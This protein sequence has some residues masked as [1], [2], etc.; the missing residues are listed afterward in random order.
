ME[1]PF[2]TTPA[3][4]RA[5][6]LRWLSIAEKLLSARDLMGSKSFATRAREADPTLSPAGEI[7]AVA[8]TLLSGDRRIGN[9][10]PDFY[11]VLRLT[12]PQGGDA[13]LVASQYRSLVVL[14]N[15]QNNRFPY[16]EQAFRLVIDAWSVLSNPSRK[17]LYDKELG[18]YLHHQQHQP[19]PFSL[20]IPASAPASQ[21]SFI[22]A[23]PQVHGGESSNVGTTHHAQAQQVHA[24]PRVGP[25]MGGPTRESQNFMGFHSGSNVVFGSKPVHEPVNNQGQDN[26]STFAGYN[27]ASSASGVTQEQNNNNKGKQSHQNYSNAGDSNNNN[28][29]DVN[30]NVEETVEEI[31]EDEEEEEKRE[32]LPLKNDPLTFWTACPYC[33][34]MYEYPRVYID[35]T[36]RCPNCKRAFQSVVIP[37]PPPT[38]DGQDAYYCCWGFIP[39]GFSMDIYEKNKGPAPT[40]GTNSGR[41]NS[42]PRV[43][44]DDDDIFADISSSSESDI[45]WQDDKDRKRKSYSNGKNVK[46]NEAARTPTRRSKKVLADK[47]KNVDVAASA[48]KTTAGDASKF[49]NAG[50]A[51]KQPNRVAKSFGKLDLNVELSNEADEPANKGNGPGRREDDNIEGIGFFEGLDELFSN[52]PILNAVGDDK[53]VKAA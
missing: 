39:L 29:D 34:Y 47:G 10:Q 3:A 28:V 18:F 49:G 46:V 25:T 52:L 12:P 38:V 21:Q 53:V 30:E 26:Y 44:V 23:Q 11:S 7:L 32:D 50:G 2:F 9:N 45:D 8:D 24:Q 51:R 36:M 15:P 37:S 4:T 42:G 27:V 35:C 43:Y 22:F 17:S 48:A 40:T 5:E 1:H 13:E 31:I 6:A 16:A 19:D 33:Y 20:P 14:L 41:R